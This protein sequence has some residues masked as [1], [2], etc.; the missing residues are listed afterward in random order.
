MGIVVFFG[1]WLA[2][3]FIAAAAVEMCEIAGRRV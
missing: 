2:L 1:L 3:V